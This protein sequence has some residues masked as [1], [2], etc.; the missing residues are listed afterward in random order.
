ML[1]KIKS[2]GYRAVR[3]VRVAGFRRLG[4]TIGENVNL[5]PHAH[6]D[7]TYPKGVVIG[8][9]STIG[10]GAR[11]L[12]HDF[13]NNAH[14]T[15]RIGSNCFIGAHAVITPGAIIGDHCIIGAGAVVGGNVPANSLV[16]GN[17]GR[18]VESN[19]RTGRW[20]QRLTTPR[21]VKDEVAAVASGDLLGSYLGDVDPTVPFSDQDIDSF[22]LVTLRAEIEENEGSQI[23]D[24]LWTEIE[25]PADLLQ[26]IT[27]PKSGRSG[28]VVGATARRSYEM[29]MPQMAVGGLSENWMFK[30]V[31][32]MHWSILT[33]ALGVKS[34]EIADQAGER[35][36]AT[37]TRMRWSADVPLVRFAENDTLDI[38]A[39]TT[40]YGAGMFFSTMDL[41]S[42]AGRIKFE[43]MSNFSKFGE[44]GGNTSMTKGQPAIPDGFAIPSLPEHPEFSNGFREARK[45]LDTLPTSIWGTEYQ[46]Q[47]Q[48]DVN[49]VGLVYFASYPLIADLCL[50]RYLERSELLAWSPVERDICYFANAD[51]EDL[52]IYRIHSDDQTRNTR[53]IVATLRRDSDGKAMALINL[54]LQRVKAAAKVRAIA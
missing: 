33:G 7:T 48:T 23:S 18:V 3:N 44:G 38:T 51:V 30:E 14:K 25:R 43:I 53:K 39:A 15:T 54:T 42:D 46:L 1:H 50:N 8:D 19:I 21:R 36:Y 13:P 12:T 26:F 6:L 47:P 28:S 31:G 22:M 10:P 17:P 29:N 9:Y 4:M 41:K 45:S 40:R 2:A 49:G 32:D 16:A 27:K 20:G 11:V 24:E 37:F 52:L 5:S 35:L 34:R